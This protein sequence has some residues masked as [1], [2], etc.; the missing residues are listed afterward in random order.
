MLTEDAMEKLLP[1]PT[2]GIWIA[3][4]PSE[5]LILEIS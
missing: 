2:E 4:L 1:Y 5:E 3:D